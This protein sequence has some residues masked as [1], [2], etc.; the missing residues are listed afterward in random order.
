MLSVQSASNMADIKQKRILFS[1]AKSTAHFLFSAENYLCLT[2]AGRI[3]W[4]NLPLLL[5][6]LN[7]LDYVLL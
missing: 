2:T 5:L 3:S 7:Q 1:Y 6:F 4:N